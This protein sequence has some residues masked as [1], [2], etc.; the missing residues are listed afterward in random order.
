[1]LD[2][3]NVKNIMYKFK[4]I[5]NNTFKIL[6]YITST[7]MNVDFFSEILHNLASS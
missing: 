5:Q 4:M 6:C 2:H 1:M 7:M 3:G